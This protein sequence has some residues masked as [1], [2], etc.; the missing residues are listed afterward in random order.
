MTLPLSEECREIEARIN[1]GKLLSREQ[2]R[3]KVSC[4][5]CLLLVDSDS[6]IRRMR[7]THIAMLKGVECLLALAVDVGGV[8]QSF[9][10]EHVAKGERHRVACEDCATFHRMASWVKMARFE[11]RAFY[12]IARLLVEARATKPECQALVRFMPD[13]GEIDEDAYQAIEDHHVTCDW[14]Q[15]YTAINQRPISDIEHEALSLFVRVEAVARTT[16]PSL[17]ELKVSEVADELRGHLAWC[18]P[19][20]DERRRLLAGE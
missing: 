2:E 13:P 1:D 8:G 7:L 3:H 12:N 4:R 9:G 15:V 5:L 20:Q 17:D 18:A 19:C 10:A 6:T 11:Q 14:C 16:C